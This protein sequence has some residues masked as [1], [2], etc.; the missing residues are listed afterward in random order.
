MVVA[1]YDN[2]VPEYWEWSWQGLFQFANTNEAYKLGVNYLVY[3]LT[4]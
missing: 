1:N 2:D 3:A 4:R